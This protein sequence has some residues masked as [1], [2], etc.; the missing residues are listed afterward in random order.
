MQAGLGSLLAFSFVNQLDSLASQ[1]GCG[2][3]FSAQVQSLLVPLTNSITDEAGKLI[4]TFASGFPTT[5]RKE[6]YKCDL[7]EVYPHDKSALNRRKD[8]EDPTQPPYYFEGKKLGPTQ[9]DIIPYE[10]NFF[11]P[12]QY[13]TSGLAVGA[14]SAPPL[15]INAPVDEFLD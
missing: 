4:Q 12:T 10:G 7:A 5:E 6:V 1:L 14:Y 8:R 2:S 13:S 15:A 3:D 11:L 9:L